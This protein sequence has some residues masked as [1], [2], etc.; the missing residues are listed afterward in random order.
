[1][2]RAF[3]LGLLAGPVFLVIVG[4]LESSNSAPPEI[5]ERDYKQ[6]MQF[7]KEGRNQEALSSFL[8]V[9]DERRDAPES[10]LQAGTLYLQHLKDP[11]SAIYHF[12]KYLETDPQSRRAN[13][14]RQLI[15]SSMK[16]F[17]RTFPAQPFQGPLERLD[18]MEMVEQV[19]T[20]NLELKRRLLAA[21]LKLEQE[22][23]AVMLR[24]RE[25]QPLR[26]LEEVELREVDDEEEGAPAA[27]QVPVSRPTSYSVE[28]G[29][30]L[31]RISVK[32]YGTPA[33]WMDI[34][35]ANRDRL[36]S[37]HDLRVGQELRIP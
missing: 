32:V 37:P 13:R 36:A 35:Q 3:G 30:N 12:R 25:V 29:D 15:E 8:I 4:C 7:L 16:E 6:G 14:V 28:A 24:Q 2:F 27:S 31:S 18:L 22:E 5:R 1:M 20:E 23:Q 19:R 10:H 21:K 17:A 11:I 26:D 33:R 9:I 34:Y